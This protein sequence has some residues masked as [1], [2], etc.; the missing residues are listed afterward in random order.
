MGEGTDTVTESKIPK[1]GT[2]Q[3]LAQRPREK[4]PQQYA[5]C[6]AHA[7]NVYTVGP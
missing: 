5:L 4:I 6:R 1:S 7:L 2:L 3:T